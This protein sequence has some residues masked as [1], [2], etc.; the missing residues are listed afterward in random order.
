M[1]KVVE[2]RPDSVR[3]LTIDAGQAGQRIDNF[4]K[5]E[6]KGVPTSHIYRILRS[7]EVR[8]NSGRVKP[9]YR[10]GAGDVLRIPPVRRGA[11]STVCVPGH[12]LTDVEAAVL[13]EDDNFLALDKPA[14]MA[15]HGGS[16]L[17]FGL[18]DALR[19]SRPQAPFLTLVHR[20]DRAT[21]GCLLVAKTRAALT[22]VH[23][24]LRNG[25]V[26]KRY[27]ALLAGSLPQHPLL[28]DE[29]LVRAAHAGERRT[30][31]S[32]DGKS[33][34]TEFIVWERFE[35]CTLA[36]VRIGTGRTHQI[37]VHAAGLGH[38]VAGDDKYGDFA[39]NRELRRLGLNR[40]FLHAWRLEFSLPACGRRYRIE[41]QL[42]PG[43]RQFVDVL[44]DECA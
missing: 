21:S 2:N 23:A 3:K 33:A 19:Q 16:G 31:I 17:G 44:R 11:D 32:A 24:L 42:P 27:L 37:R 10:L 34:Q 43:L 41:A 7:G 25:R 30:R 5:R 36:A 13:L 12:L 29:P 40:L 38:P 8:V 35:R 15:V 26:E 9:A 4:L 1:T 22:E 28:T 14:G 18:I 39:F 6:L 20:L